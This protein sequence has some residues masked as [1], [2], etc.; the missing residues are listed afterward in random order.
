MSCN[1]KFERASNP[2]NRHS[3]IG[4][5]KRHVSFGNSKRHVSFGSSKRHVSCGSS[6]R[7]VSSSAFRPVLEPN[8]PLIR[9]IPKALRAGL[10][11][12]GRESDHSIQSNAVVKKDWSNTYN[13]PTCLNGVKRGILYLNYQILFRFRNNWKQEGSVT[14]LVLL[15]DESSL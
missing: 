2:R 11:L 7:H 10:K 4:S 3:T 15:M 12:P 8:H 1:V 14:S 9:W 5:S 13:C 6:K